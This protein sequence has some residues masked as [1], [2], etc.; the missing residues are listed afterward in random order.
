MN[1][2]AL[3]TVFFKVGKTPLHSFP[4]TTVIRLYRNWGLRDN[5]RRPEVLHTQSKKVR[6]INGSTVSLIIDVSLQD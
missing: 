2:G 6:A 1:I 3:Q 5:G 4:S